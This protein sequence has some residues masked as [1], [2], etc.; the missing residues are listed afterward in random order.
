MKI[1]KCWLILICFF[2]FIPSLHA[3]S[4]IKRKPDD[5]HI[6]KFAGDIWYVT[7][8]GN[9]SNGGK[10]PHDAKLTITATETAASAND[11]IIV[12]SG[13]FT[14][15]VTI[16]QNGIEL[17]GE[18]G[19]ILVGTLTISA[20]NIRV[21]GI[22]IQAI[23]VIGVDLDG[24]YC[25]I[26]DTH[27]IGTPTIGF[28][29]DG[30]YTI[31]TDCKAIGHTVTAFDMANTRIH[32]YRCIAHGSGGATRGFY[33]SSDAAD[34]CYLENCISTG[35][36]TSGYEVVLGCSYIMVKSSCSGGGDGPRVDLGTKTMWCEFDDKLPRE[37]HEEVYPAAAGEGG[38]A[39]PI[40]VSNL[41]QDK[42]G[43]QDDQWYWG[44]PKIIIAPTV[45]TG[46][47]SLLGYNIFATTSNKEM[48]A[49]IYRINYVIQSDKNGGNAWD[50]GATVLTVDDGSR[51]STGD[52][53]WIYSDHKTDGE[54]VEVSS[55][56]NNEVTIARETVASGRAGLRWDH[57]TNNAGTEVMY[58]IYRSIL[59][60]MHPTMI[61]Y[62]ASSGKDFLINHFHVVKE[63]RAN[64]G[65]LIRMLNMNDN[66]ACEFDI[67][68]I[69]ED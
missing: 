52:L 37:H 50:E 6:E 55:V 41:A 66:L 12:G 57:T 1:I 19:S 20:D 7:K 36:E 5:E 14:E 34:L 2:I 44:E 26:N 28:D 13:T 10:R 68:A 67:T 27:V 54:I 24:D 17:Y 43:T 58:L 25:K 22:I 35:N 65:I 61:N 45:N 23:G 59:D 53:V 16:D 33:F 42:T 29:I 39:L 40:N 49:N 3:E 21:D 8:S 47:W 4:L 64:D 32:L 9:D 31:I 30:A 56:S 62:S 18:V 51:F 63:F 15:S 48:Q 60:D 38:A 69:W 46:I 11:K